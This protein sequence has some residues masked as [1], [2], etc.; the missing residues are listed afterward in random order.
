MQ[1]RVDAVCVGILVAD[2]FCSPVDSIPDPGELTLADRF[3]LNAGGCAVNTAACL[4][5]AGK[6]ARVIG[7]IGDDLFGDF[8]IRD[9]DRLGVDPGGVKR[10]TSLPTSSTFILNVRGQDRRYIHLI[11]A[12]ADLCDADVDLT[13]LDSTGVLYV[14]G[15]LAMPGFSTSG[16]ARL[17]RM[18][19]KKSVQ[20]VL[21][22]M[23]AAGRRVSLADIEAAL[24]YTDVFLPNDDEAR[25]LTGE[26]SPLDQM[27]CLARINPACSIVITRGERGLVARDG[28][29]VWDVG[30]YRLNTLDESGAGDAFAAGIVTGL[31]EGWPFERQL[32]F[33]SAMG[34]S[35][36]TA[37]GCTAGVFRFDE[38]VHFIEHNPLEIKSIG[39]REA[40]SAWLS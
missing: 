38:A 25:A 15:F 8:L 34:A 27:A 30:T 28:G 37:L 29:Q 4:R 16:L 1:S 13:S 23:V 7:K 14:G 22:V 35:C 2:I 12:N 31:A 39:I 19:R 3:L 18:A 26:A 10:S 6:Q 24:P 20:T 11:G 40:S 21:D 36:T 17:F 33:A 9:L 32:R 5:R